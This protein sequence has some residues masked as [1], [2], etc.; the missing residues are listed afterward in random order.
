M[1]MRKFGWTNVEVSLIGQ[2]TWMIEGTNHRNTYG[3]AIE[4]LRLGLEVGMNHIDTAEMYGNGVV[5]ELVG[6]AIAGRQQRREEI[7]LV[8][9]V[10]P[11][12]ASYYDTLRG[13][14]R[15]LQRLNTDYLDLYLIHWPSSDHPIGETMRAMETLV[16]EGKVKFIGVSNFDL[17]QLQ[18]AENA[19]QNEK[20]A[21]NQV[22][23]N[24]NSRGI[25]RNLLPY[26]LKKG[27]AIVG[28]SPFGHG[29][30]P[31]VE[32]EGGR[33]LVEIAERHQKT[34]YQVVLNFIINH[35][36]IFTIPKTSRPNRV[37]ENSNSIGW[38]L[39]ESD[40]KAINQGFPVPKYDVPLEMI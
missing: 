16:K 2:G 20:I 36:N 34:P 5:E 39:T 8:S 31:S 1:I 18:E 21:C 14:D 23:Y 32:S 26:C 30:F 29:Y 35:T 40:I 15:S 12:N 38:K 19:L 7:F 3:I 24:L 27:I 6:R 17:K 37:L 13:C 4:S 33:I 10:L 22:M 25:E 28:Y 9:K 11:S